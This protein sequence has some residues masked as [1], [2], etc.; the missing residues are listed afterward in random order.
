MKKILVVDDD[1][2]FVESIRASL[3]V[4]QYTVA[5]ARDGAE[6]LKKMEED[7]PDLILLDMA[8]P[9]MDGIEFL[10]QVN[11]KYGEGRTPVL[12]TSNI[13]TLEKISEGMELGIAG[14]IDRVFKE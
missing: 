13:S 3:D 8:M 11:K 2:A 14:I 10:K 5:S 7:R 6:G 9:T 12:I 1:S 4:S